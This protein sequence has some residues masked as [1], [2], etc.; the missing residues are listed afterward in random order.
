MKRLTRAGVIKKSTPMSS[1]VY[2][3]PGERGATRRVQRLKFVM[4]VRKRGR[5][6]FFHVISVTRVESGEGGLSIRVCNRERR[7]KTAPMERKETGR[8]ALLQWPL[9][10]SPGGRKRRV[11]VITRA[12][13]AS[14]A[15]IAPLSLSLVGQMVID[16]SS[17]TRQAHYKKAGRCHCP[18]RIARRG[19]AEKPSKMHR[20]AIKASLEQRKRPL[21]FHNAN[22]FIRS[23][24]GARTQLSLK[25]VTSVRVK[26]QLARGRIEKRRGTMRGGLPRAREQ[27][28]HEEKWLASS[29]SLAER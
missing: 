23:G 14:I 22:K 26:I 27:N 2:S 12:S 28:L 10:K 8:A 18:A 20:S 25:S 17:A 13:I 3:R 5:L 15:S 11:R 21:N 19:T 29:L 6:V 9:P 24:V 7:T 4:R 16:E 1:G